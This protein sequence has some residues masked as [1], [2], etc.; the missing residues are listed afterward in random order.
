MKKKQKSL[1]LICKKKI[2]EKAKLKPQMEFIKN[3][4][5]IK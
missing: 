3:Q 4:E 5:K 1:K 2:G